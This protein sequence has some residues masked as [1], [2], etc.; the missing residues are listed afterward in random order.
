MA[1]DTTVRKVDPP[2]LMEIFAGGGIAAVF[3][4]SVGVF[5][6]IVPVIGWVIGPGLMILAGV[7]AIAHIGG[8]FKR[9]PGY[10]GH[11]PHC[12]A[13][14]IVGAPGTSGECEACKHKFVHRDAHL[15]EIA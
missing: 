11:C 15:M 12:G 7:I 14:A 3:L 4:F 8:M 2:A 6:S 9:K 1:I 10:A 5:M 13:E